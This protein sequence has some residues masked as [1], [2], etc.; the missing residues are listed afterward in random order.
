[1]RPDAYR[2]ETNL[3]PHFSLHHVPE[4]L[5]PE[6]ISDRSRELVKLSLWSMKRTG[7]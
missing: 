2:M 5:T 7:D 3:R 4:P 6:R 1:M